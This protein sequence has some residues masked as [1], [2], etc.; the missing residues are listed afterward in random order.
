M[1]QAPRSAYVNHAR[2]ELAVTYLENDKYSQALTYLHQLTDSVA[3][4][5]FAPQSWMKTGFVY[6][7]MGDNAKAIEAYKHVVTGYPA[8]EDRMPA[9][10]ALKSL[11]IQGNQPGAYSKLLR[12]YNLPSGDSSS[13]DSTYY[14]AAETQFSSGKWQEAKDGFDNY[15]REYPNGIFATKAR[16]YRAESNYQLKQYKEARDD[17]KYILST[18]QCNEFMENSALKAAR[19]SFEEKAYAEAF[20]FYSQLRGCAT[21]GSVKQQAYNG[22]MKSGFQSGK[23]NEAAS[24]ADSLLST[25]GI[26]T[27][28]TNDALYYKARSLQQ[29]DS[30]DAALAIYRQLS[31]DKSGEIAAESR[32]RIA[33]LLLKQGKLKEAEDAANQA[34]HLSAGYDYWIVKSYLVLADLLAR[35]K[36]YFNARATLQSVVKHTKITE[37]KLEAEKKLDEVNKLEKNQSKLSE[38]Q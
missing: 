32:Y 9:L 37:L 7:Q 34:I 14:A 33:E 29:F 10:D 36:D 1:S 16:Y 25:P 24:F 35:Q 18:G 12:D 5:S 20:D 22:L 6:Q 2:Y 4:K 21:T 8:S 3:D 31:T 27:E 11:Y 38:E 28:V 30:T 26:S 13:L 19:I 23:Y 17:Y 15:L